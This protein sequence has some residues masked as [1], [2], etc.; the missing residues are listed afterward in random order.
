MKAACA[1]G[2]GRLLHRGGTRCRCAHRRAGRHSL[3]G[4]RCGTRGRWSTV[5]GTV[6]W[7]L[8]LLLQLSADDGSGLYVEFVDMETAMHVHPREIHT[9]RMNHLA[10]PAR[11]LPRIQPRRHPRSP[12]HRNKMHARALSRPLRLP[13]NSCY[14]MH[15]MTLLA[16][17]SCCCSAACV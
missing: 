1:E 2:L 8:V 6:V 13:G 17:L 5:A 4:S 7:L 3:G 11:P 15:I 12:E 16:L 10:P 9:R 14:C